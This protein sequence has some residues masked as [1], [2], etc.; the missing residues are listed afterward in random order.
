[1]R[2]LVVQTT[3]MGD[4]IQTG[5]LIS[6]IRAEH[7]R[8]HIAV[9]SRGLAKTVAERHPEVDE[10]VLY[11]ENTMFLDMRS[12]DS[13]RL[14]RAYEQAETIIHTL[15]EKQFDLAYNMTHSVASAIML[16]LAKIP[17]VVGAHLSEDWRFVL[18]GPWTTYFFTSVFSRD[19]NDLNLC[20]I[21]RSFA[22]NAPVRHTLSFEVHDADTAHVDALFAEHHIDP[23]GFIVCLQLGASEQNKRW[24]ESRF[25]E[26]AILLKEKYK[27]QILLVGV[28]E[29]S[30]YGEIFERHAPGIA[31]HLFGKTSVP[32]LAALL[33]RAQLLVTNDTGTMHLAAAV[34][35]PIVLISVGHVHFRETGPYI[36]GA[37]AMETRRRTLGRS[38]YVPGGNEERD[39]IT[40]DQALVGV[41]LALGEEPHKPLTHEDLSNIDIYQSHFAVDDCLHFLPLIPRPFAQVDLLRMAYRCMWLDNLSPRGVDMEKETAAITHWMA[42]YE[43]TDAKTLGLL[44]DPVVEAAGE[45]AAKAHN[46]AADTGK[47]LAILQGQGSMGEAKAIVARLMALDEETRVYS[48]VHPPLRPLVLL[49]RFERENLE[50]VDALPL[51]QTTLQ[52]YSDLETRAR[53]LLTKLERLRQ[54]LA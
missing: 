37:I 33:C 20:D 31:V 30:A 12:G 9:L 3:R 32:Q 51:A 10:V 54:L 25:A 18:R 38:D 17:T 21:A 43:A 44:L 15:R 7:P 29:E 50:G 8:A 34:N 4:M 13:D 40:G 19:F 47:L 45:L 5:P 39:R 28:P 6:Q 35:C 16:C 41:A 11:D 22:L 2:I 48:E 23:A 36:E 52:I 1:M 24:A 14:R 42:A 53:L 27:A 49:A 46:G 26:L